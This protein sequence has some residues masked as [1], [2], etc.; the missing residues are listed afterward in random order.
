MKA[1][2]SRDRSAIL[3]TLCVGALL[4]SACEREPTGLERASSVVVVS[5]D[6]QSGAAGSA[7]KDALIV[8]VLDK[9][10]QPVAGV[11]VDWTVSANGGQ[12]ATTQTV[13]NELGQASTTWSV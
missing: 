12:L 2:I 1:T 10:G 11:T 4:Y 7:L 3:L 6:A 9:G 13:T 8:R 5:G